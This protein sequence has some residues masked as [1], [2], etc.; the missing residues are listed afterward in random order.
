MLAASHACSMGS[1]FD[2][3]LRAAVAA[4]AGGAGAAEGLLL[5]A[6]DYLRAVPLER[7]GARDRMRSALA[8]YLRDLPAA[9]IDPPA[10]SSRRA[11]AQAQLRL[12]YAQQRLPDGRPEPPPPTRG[13]GRPKHSSD[14]A[15]AAA[16]RCWT[17]RADIS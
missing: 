8:A 13:S 16:A 3:D 12:T 17:R 5:A 7:E 4:L 10:N 9:R 6:E 2:P 11:P 15:R 1:R 14:R